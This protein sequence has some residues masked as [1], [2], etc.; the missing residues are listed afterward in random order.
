[1][2]SIIPILPTKSSAEKRS[3][4]F[5]YKPFQNSWYFVLRTIIVSLNTTADFCARIVEVCLF[6][7]VISHCCGKLN[8]A[9]G[10]LTPNHR[11]VMKRFSS[12]SR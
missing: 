5:T 9:E 11:N 1:M 6:Q 8:H 3:Q 4:Q 2:L 10:I 7:V 12:F